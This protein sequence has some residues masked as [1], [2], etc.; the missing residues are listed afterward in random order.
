[1]RKLVTAI[2]NEWIGTS[3][4]PLTIAVLG[5]DSG[6][7]ELEHLSDSVITFYGIEN[8]NDDPRFRE[9]DL[10]S[11]SPLVL[12]DENYELVLCSQVIEHLYN[13]PQS[14]KLISSLVKPGGYIWLGFPASNMPHG[15]PEYYA[16]GYPVSTV[17]KLLPIEFEIVLSGQ[18]GTKRNYLWTHSLREWPPLDELNHP[19]LYIWRTDTSLI[20]KIIRVL[21]RLCKAQI[22]LADNKIRVDIEWATESYLLAKRLVV[23]K[24]NLYPIMEPSSN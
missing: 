11:D 1:M 19:F 3:T 12:P 21:R 2:F 22:V 15:S 4:K 7:P 8:T 6:E 23:N 24:S 20:R 13:L 18:I 16:A 10:N 9:L 17:I 5:G 14:I